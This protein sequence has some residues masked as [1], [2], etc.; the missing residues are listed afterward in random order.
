MLA[1][2]QRIK[3]VP[4]C[5]TLAPRIKAA[6]VVRPSAMP[7]AAMTGTL[8]A[9]TIWVAAKI[10]RLHADIDTGEC[11]AMAT[12]LAALGND[13]VNA[14]PLEQGRFRHR[15]RAR[16][17]EDAG[18][19]DRIDNSLIGQAEVEA[20]DFWLLFEKHCDGL[21]ANITRHALRLRHRPQSLIVVV[22]L[23]MP[24]HRL[25]G[26]RGISRLRPKRV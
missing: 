11:C 25:T 24:P 15:C 7:P 17:D 10:A 1:S 20:D 12:R 9:T 21:G 6:A 4:S 22:R 26:F 3:A 2:S 13:R 14:A 16:L 23:Q 18:G 8:T 19:F 5:T